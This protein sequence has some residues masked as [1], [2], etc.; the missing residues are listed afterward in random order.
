MAVKGLALRPRAR[1]GVVP[2]TIVGDSEEARQLGD[3]ARSA[4]RLELRAQSRSTVRA[5]LFVGRNSIVHNLGRVPSGFTVSPTVA[6]AAFA[7]AISRDGTDARLIAIDV[8]GIAQP[9]A[10]I[11]VY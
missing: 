6:S 2:T 8:I 7:A 4:Q 3:L 10:T 11:E 1:P 5:T 9:D